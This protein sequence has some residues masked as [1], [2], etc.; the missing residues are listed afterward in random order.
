EIG[1]KKSKI[2]SERDSSI[3]IVID[4]LIMKNRSKLVFYGKKKVDLQVKYAEID[5]AYILGTDGK[6]NGSDMDITIRF[7]KLGNLWVSAA[8]DNAANGSKTFPN[9]NGGNITFKYLSDGITPQQED[10]RKSAYLLI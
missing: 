2:F 3:A 7:A 1:R 6:N 9:G 4:T 8:G 10:K 5:N